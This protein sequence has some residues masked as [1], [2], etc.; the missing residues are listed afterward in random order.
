MIESLEGEN[1]GWK[2]LLSIHPRLI[3]LRTNS[4]AVTYRG[5]TP[6][7]LPLSHLQ[8]STYFRTGHFVVRV[9]RVVRG[10]SAFAD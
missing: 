7:T 8:V 2:L 9:F 4:P 6:V 5:P 10:S 3:F 1:M